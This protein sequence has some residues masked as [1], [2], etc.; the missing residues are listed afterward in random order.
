MFYGIL[1]KFTDFGGIDGY[2]NEDRPVLIWLGV[3]PLG[4]TIR[5]Q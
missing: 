2:M 5:M 4:S 1:L 3:L